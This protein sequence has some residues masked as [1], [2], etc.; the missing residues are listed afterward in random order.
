MDAAFVDDHCTTAAAW[1]ESE[2]RFP[3]RKADCVFERSAANSASVVRKAYRE[4]ALS[5]TQ[6]ERLE[7]V[8]GWSWKP[9]QASPAFDSKVAKLTEWMNYHGQIPNS[10]SDD[11]DEVVLGRWVKCVRNEHRQ[12]L[13][14]DARSIAL[15]AVPGWEWSESNH[16]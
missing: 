6:I 7:S 11:D 12:G 14:T 4:G 9:V 1:L 15:E 13:M 10:R 2:R 3:V 16:P 5:S 8:P